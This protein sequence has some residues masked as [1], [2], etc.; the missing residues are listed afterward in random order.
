MEH[1]GQ[2]EDLA[3]DLKGRKRILLWGAM[4]A[5]KSTLALELARWFGRHHGGGRILALDPGSP[6]FGVPGALNRGRWD[7]DAL[8]WDGCRALCTLD[9]ARFRLPPCPGRQP[10]P[11]RRCRSRFARS[12]CHRSAGGG[13]GRCRCRTAHGPCQGT[14]GGSGAGPGAGG[15][16]P[17][18]GC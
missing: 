10:S 15:R 9:A 14:P 17:A 13:P 8:H 6:A 7:G 1:K 18:P 4:G 3:Q 12:P 2:I 16:L 11:E 5:G